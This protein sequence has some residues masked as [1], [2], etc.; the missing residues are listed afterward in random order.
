MKDQRY[1]HVLSVWKAGDLTSFSKIFSIVPKS[2]VSVDLGL[3]YGR[4]AR[5]LNNPDLLSF[6]EI[7]KMAQ[8]FNLDYRV[9][10]GLVLQAIDEKKKQAFE[11]SMSAY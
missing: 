9:I 2:I 8:L 7:I 11:A 4:F 5:K 10:V 1:N 6:S 3:N